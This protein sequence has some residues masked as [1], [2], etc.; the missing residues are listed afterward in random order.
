MDLKVNAIK[1]VFNAIVSSTER[2][3]T[4]SNSIMQCVRPNPIYKLVSNRTFTFDDIYS[5]AR[6]KNERIKIIPKISNVNGKQLYSFEMPEYLYHVTNEDKMKLI[7][8]TRKIKVSENEQLPGIYLL[9]KENFLKNYINVSDK[10]YNLIDG[11]IKQANDNKKLGNLVLIRI[12]TTNLLRNGK[13]RIRTQEDFLYFQN[14]IIELQK[15]LKKKHLLRMFKDDTIRN[16]LKKHII[17]NKLMT[18][19]EAETFFAEMKSKIHYGY[20]IEQFERL[21]KSKAVEFVFNR[22]ITP[23]LIKGIKIRKFSIDMCYNSD[24]TIN[25][26]KLRSIFE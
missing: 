15:G 24:G 12:P 7:N 14:K 9:D 4:R 1:P 2:F 23:D 10:N 17:D 22:D 8:S 11:M 19:A 3:A 16:Y 26:E 25:I 13:I 21:D 18:N 6:L 20:G 5:I